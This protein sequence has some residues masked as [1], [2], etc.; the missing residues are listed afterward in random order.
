MKSIVSKLLPEQISAF[1]DVI[2]YAVAQS[3]PPISS[4]HPDI[5]NRVL[6]SCLSG[7]TEVWAEYTKDKE[8][9]TRFEGI[10]LTQFLY[11]K[12]SDTKNLLVYCLYGYQKIDPDSW[13]RTMVTIA[14]YAKEKNC[15]QII[16]Y[17]SIPH[18]I[19]L[20][21]KLGANTDY[22]FISFNVDETIQL[23]NELDEV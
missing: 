7:V 21:R 6:S 2:Q 14:K 20:T 11:D 16:A 8:G 23:L 18:M 13:G 12:T 4:D 9:N 5:M 10:A 1:W 17:S 22:T 3:L 19:E 15:A